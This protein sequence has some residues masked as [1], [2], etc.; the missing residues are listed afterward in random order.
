LALDGSTLR[1][2]LALGGAVDTVEIGLEKAVGQTRL[3]KRF[4]R[5][6][7]GVTNG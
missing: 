2:S 1:R 7:R 6:E 5:N 4:W 3:F